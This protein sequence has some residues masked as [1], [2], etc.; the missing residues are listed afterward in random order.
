MHS[1]K[2][3]YYWQYN[4]QSIRRGL[5][6]ERIEAKKLLGLGP[7]LGYERAWPT[8]GFSVL[9]FKQ[10]AGLPDQRPKCQV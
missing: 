5:V 9:F 8:L 6:G 10:P 2:R 4:I 7:E 1:N 3:I